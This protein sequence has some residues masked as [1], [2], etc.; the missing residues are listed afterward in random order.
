[1]IAD[2]PY[3]A[4]KD[5]EAIV[6]LTEWQDFRLLDWPRIAAAVRQPIIVDTRNLLDPDVMRRAK[7]EWIGVGRGGRRRV[8]AQ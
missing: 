4:A 3:V 5:A 8:G 6:I 2:D 1:T 7:L